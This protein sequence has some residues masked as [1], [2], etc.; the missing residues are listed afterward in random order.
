[1]IYSTLSVIGKLN[2]MQHKTANPLLHVF[3]ILLTSIVLSACSS[4]TNKEPVVEDAK[5]EAELYASAIAKLEGGN[6]RPAI[7]DLVAMEARYP[8]G[9]YSEQ[10]QLELIYAYYRSFQPAEA[11]TAAARFIRLH[12]DHEHVDYAYY[13]KGLTAF[14]ENKGALDQYIGTDKA[15]KDPGAARDSFTDFSTLIKRFPSSEYAAD[16]RVRMVYLRNLLAAHEIHVATY[17]ISIKAW[18]AAANR[19]KYV[20]E[21]YQLTPAVEIALQI[22]VQAYTE[23]GLSDNA[24]NAQQVLDANFRTRDVSE[25]T[26]D[27][28]EAEEQQAPEP[29]SWLSRL[30]FNL[31]D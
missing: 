11:K 18:L 13:L 6:Y 14:E 29:R 10:A 22:M 19:A 28:S 27:P 1:M 23:L 3:A 30:T 5:P 7:E 16:S 8:Y 9:R 26:I 24:S 21:N 2:T 25:A 12:P 4:T 15:K 20:V 17:Y 31:F